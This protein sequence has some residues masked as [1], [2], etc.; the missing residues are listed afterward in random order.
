MKAIKNPHFFSI[1][2]HS[3]YYNLDDSCENKKCGQAC[4]WELDIAG[5]CNK[6]GECTLDY[7]NL[8]CE[9]NGKNL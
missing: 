8:G 5:R 6:R 3:Q 1:E 9:M 7:N 4:K 2:Y